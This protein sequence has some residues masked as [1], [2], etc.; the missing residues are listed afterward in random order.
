MTYKSIITLLFFAPLLHP[1]QG[2]SRIP[3]CTSTPRTRCPQTNTSTPRTIPDSSFEIG[4]PEIEQPLGRDG[5]FGIAQQPAFPGVRPL[6]RH[7][8]PARPVAPERQPFAFVR[9]AVPARY[10]APARP[11]IPRTV[12]GNNLL[13]EEQRLATQ[14]VQNPVQQFGLPGSPSYADM[15]R[16]TSN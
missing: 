3:S 12:P 14:R 4:A 9:H 1:S 7:I 2:T 6:A 5:W 15:A 8:V 13:P 10:A 11:T 16:R